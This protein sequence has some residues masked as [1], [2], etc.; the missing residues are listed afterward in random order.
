MLS[1]IVFV[2]MSASVALASA[3]L[4]HAKATQAQY[5]KFLAQM[6]AEAGVYASFNATQSL[7][8]TELDRGNGRIIRYETRILGSSPTFGIQSTGSVTVHDFTYISII[9]ATASNGIITQWSYGS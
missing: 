6:A 7:N 8:P 1:L 3:Q 4:V 9:Q 2:F 5:S